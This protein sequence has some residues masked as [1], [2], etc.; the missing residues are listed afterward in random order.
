MRTDVT[1]TCEWNDFF[2]T[3]ECEMIDSMYDLNVAVVSSELES[4]S[5][6]GLWAMRIQFIFEKIVQLS[7]IYVTV[8]ISL[9]Y[10]RGLKG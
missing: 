3:H 1:A 9:T 5:A 2:L 7:G 6:I 4:Y 8:W 10:H